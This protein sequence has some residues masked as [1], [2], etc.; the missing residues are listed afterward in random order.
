MAKVAIFGTKSY[1]RQFLDLA[2]IDNIHELTYFEPRLSIGTVRLITDQ[3]TV[4][5]FVNDE[6]D[7]ETL[8]ALKDAGIGL[9]ALRCAGFNN[10]D[11]KAAARLGM[12]VA[13]VPSYSPHAVAEHTVAMMLTLIR[14]THRAYNRVREG[15]LSLEGSLGF[16]LQGKSIGVIGT[17]S[18]GRVVATILRGFGCNL[19]AY[20]RYP[21]PENMPVPIRYVSLQELFA[22]SEIITLH[23]PLTPETHHLINRAAIDSMKPGVVLINTSRGAVVD[24][25]ALIHALKSDKIGGLGL[26]VYEEEAD[27]FFE[28][29][30]NRGIQDDVFARLITFPNVLIT[31]HQGFFTSE[32]MTA[33][34]ETTMANI[35]AFE[36]TGKPL[37]SVTLK[38]LVGS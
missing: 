14:K 34:A 7:A 12:N 18:I 20:D 30:S 5:V 19:L 26:D 25:A 24:S 27:F 10:I 22:S 37:H 15:N 35:S 13:H 6:L 16:N 38:Q 4:C 9:I 17:G 23:C 8:A 21:D 2:N 33:I 1:D 28:D 31:G 36:T 32:A 29:I 11:I 3:T